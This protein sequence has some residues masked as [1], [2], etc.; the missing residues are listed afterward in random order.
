ME[1][2]IPKGDPFEQESLSHTACTDSWIIEPSVQS[3]FRLSEY[4]RPNQLRLYFAW[5]ALMGS[6]DAS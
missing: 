5:V 2:Q 3:V 4:K 1:V 6:P